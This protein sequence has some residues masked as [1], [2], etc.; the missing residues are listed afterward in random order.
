MR[1]RGRPFALPFVVLSGGETTVTLKGAGRG[2]RNAEFLLSLAIG[3]DGLEGVTALAADTDGIDGSEANAGAFADG[4]TVSRMR[5]KG[6]DPVKA[7][8]RNDAYSAFEAV[9]DLF[10]TG[11][12]GT[13]VN[14]FRA[15]LVR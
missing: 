5:Q 2:G 6:I 4:T 7:L 14:D 13:N 15:V 3:I 11:P 12:T 1:E 8:L 9:G 10:F